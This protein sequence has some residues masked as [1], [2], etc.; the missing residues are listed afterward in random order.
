MLALGVSSRSPASAR[1]LAAG[2]PRQD[3]DHVY[4]TTDQFFR[5]HNNEFDK[6]PCKLDSTVTENPRSFEIYSRVP[7]DRNWHIETVDWN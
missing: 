2:L 7:G 4:I 3:H 1:A 6:M 5:F